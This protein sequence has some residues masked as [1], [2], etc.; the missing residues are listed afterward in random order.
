MK[1]S[2]GETERGKRGERKE[3]ERERDRQTEKV[4]IYKQAENREKGK[5]ERHGMRHE[6][7]IQRTSNVF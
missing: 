4:N 5:G 2:N 3:R 6:S 1:T 7:G